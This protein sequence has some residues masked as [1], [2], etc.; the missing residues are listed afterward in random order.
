LQSFDNVDASD[1]AAQVPIGLQVLY[2]Y[3]CYHLPW[4]ALFVHVFDVFAGFEICFICVTFYIKQY[5]SRRF[6]ML[7]DGPNMIEHD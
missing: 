1:D 2:S 4:E 6:N 7:Q 5:L 3:R